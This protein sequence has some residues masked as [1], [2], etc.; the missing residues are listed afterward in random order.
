MRK[1][2]KK[3]FDTESVLNASVLDV[4]QIYRPDYVATGFD[5]LDTGLLRKGGLPTKRII[6][7]FGDDGVGKSLFLYRV[8]GK[9][10]RQFPKKNVLL[11]DS[12]Y[13][14]DPDWAELNGVDLSRLT[15]VATNTAETAFEVLIE[16]AESGKFSLVALDSFGNLEVS[17]YMQGKRFQKDTKTGEISRDQVAALAATAQRAIKRFPAPLFENNC[18]FIYTNQ[19]RDTF[20]MYGSATNTTGGRCVKYNRNISLELVRISDIIVGGEIEGIVVRARLKKSKISPRGA[21]DTSNDLKFFFAGGETKAE[22]YDLFDK[23]IE[24]NVIVRGGAWY[25]WGAERWQGKE[26]L[27]D[28]LLNSPEL[29]D[30]LRDDVTKPVV[31][32][33]K[34]ADI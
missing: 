31:E 28:S 23:A 16:G 24:A 12:E 19:L 30:K 4:E 34:D 14:F 26:K 20:N 7:I 6:E 2:L 5:Q 3:T 33:T 22:V 17:Q 8:I 1:T 9:W 25:N 29:V 11:V 13:S 15:Y 21:T 32:E 10:Q 18:S 27:L